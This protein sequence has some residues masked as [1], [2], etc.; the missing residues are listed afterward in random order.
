MATDKKEKAELEKL[1]A[2]EASA[3]AADKAEL[4]QSEPEVKGLSELEK[5]LKSVKVDDS[6]KKKPF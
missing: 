2:T 3:D 1:A 5:D 4:K 6:I